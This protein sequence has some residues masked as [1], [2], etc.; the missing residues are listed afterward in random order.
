M[1]T[2][3][4]EYGERIDRVNED[5]CLIQKKD[6]LTFGTDAYLLAAFLR[7][8]RKGR[9]VELGAGTGI[10]SLLCAARERF[11]HVDALEIQEDFAQMAMRNVALNHLDGRVTVRHADV[12]EITP[13]ILGG[14]VDAVFAN[15]PYMRTDSGKRNES[16]RKNIARHEVCGTVA[17]F[18]CA[19]RRLLKHGGKF[20][21]VWRPDRLSELMAALNAQGLEPK[22]MVFVHGDAETEPSM[23]L[24]SAIKGGAAGMRILP[25]LLLHD[26]T[27]DRSGKRA[28]TKRAQAIY[29]TMSFYGEQKGE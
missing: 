27:E 7:P 15:P 26:V 10:V 20:Y 28:L 8:Q 13:E 5:L 19:A 11:A 12:R 29:D 23:V 16:D 3:M 1:E 9:A 24:V 6:G 2:P 21:C 17:D 22:V 25:P 14:E 18:C 4:L